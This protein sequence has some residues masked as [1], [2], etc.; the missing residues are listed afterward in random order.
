MV[1]VQVLGRRVTTHT[2]H[3]SDVQIRR[4]HQS[5]APCAT[6]RR[7]ARR[8]PREAQKTAAAGVHTAVDSTTVCRVKPC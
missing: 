8:R 2:D 1:F 7:V 5:S 3:N 6:S 4:R